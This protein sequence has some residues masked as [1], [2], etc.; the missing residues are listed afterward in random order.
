MYT[1][2][3]ELCEVWGLGGDLNVVG[4]GG[5]GRLRNALRPCSSQGRLLLTVN[6]PSIEGSDGEPG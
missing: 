5:D 6:K 2:Q 4:R 1:I 3:I